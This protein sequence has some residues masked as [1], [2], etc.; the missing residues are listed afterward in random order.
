MAIRQN[1]DIPSMKKGGPH[2]S[3]TACGKQHHLFVRER[4][5]TGVAKW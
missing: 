2:C 1:N 3:E 5:T 4:G